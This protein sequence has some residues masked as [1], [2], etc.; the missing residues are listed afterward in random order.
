MAN[1]QR[2]RRIAIAVVCTS[3]ALAAWVGV[4]SSQ[5]RGTYPAPSFEQT[6]DRIKKRLAQSHSCEELAEMARSS[7]KILARLQSAERS[8]LGRGLLAF[9]VEKPSVV[10][11]AAPESSIPF[12]LFDQG[13]TNTKTVLIN[14]DSRFV[15][16]RKRFTEG[17][18]ELGVNALDWKPRAHYAVFVTVEGPDDSQVPIVPYDPGRWKVL[19]TKPGECAFADVSRPFESLPESL[20]NA[21]TIPT[22]HD[23]RHA[24]V[25]LKGRAWKTHVPSSSIPDQIVVTP[26]QDGSRSLIWTWRTT[27]EARRVD[28]PTGAAREP[29]RL[30]GD[31]SN[32]GRNVLAGE[33]FERRER[34]GD[35]PPRGAG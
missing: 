6:L 29:F 23:M 22:R 4:R 1:N 15:L 19:K 12:W 24:A 30:A 35:S 8:D 27:P 11:I 26:G 32:R 5:P 28:T 3:A 31:L 14:E 2:V 33:D 9:R 18:V 13:F 10:W 16:F 25:L 34:P 7:T 17:L 21:W 20:S